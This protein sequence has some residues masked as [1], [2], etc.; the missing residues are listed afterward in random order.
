MFWKYVLKVLESILVG[1]LA[2]IAAVLVA[3]FAILCLLISM[4]VDA[5]MDTWSD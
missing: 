1:T 3:P 4:P 5:I 2:L